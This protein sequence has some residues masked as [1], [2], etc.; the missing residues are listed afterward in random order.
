MTNWRR[1]A[2]WTDIKDTYADRD[3]V[4]MQRLIEAVQARKEK[5]TAVIEA[6]EKMRAYLERREEYG[7]GSWVYSVS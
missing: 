2:G 4:K 1:R 6:V 3:K 7:V 5:R